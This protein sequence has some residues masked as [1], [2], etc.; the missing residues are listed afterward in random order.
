MDEA[1]QPTQEAPLDLGYDSEKLG[2]LPSVLL[3]PDKGNGD[4]RRTARLDNTLMARLVPL[5][6]DLPGVNFLFANLTKGCTVGRSSIC[7]VHISG[8]M[9]S[10][11]HCRVF[12][13]DRPETWD[14]VRPV[15][16]FIQDLSTNGTFVNGT[17]LGKN[18]RTLLMHGDTVAFPKPAGTRQSQDADYIFQSV[19]AHRQTPT[20]T[21]MEINCPELQNRYDVKHT[22]GTGNFS[23]VKLAI[24]KTSGDSYACK[25]IRKKKFSMQPKVMSSFAREV[26]ILS[27]ISHSNIIRYHEVFENEQY[28]CIMT[29]FVSGA[30]LL[31]MITEQ[32]KVTEHMGRGI[33]YQL[34]SAIEYLHQRG[35]T[36]R[37][38]KPENILIQEQTGL[39]KL[40]DFGLARSL[41]D[42]TF[43]ATMCGTPS[44]I[45]PEIIRNHDGVPRYTQLVDLWSLGVVLYHMLTGHLP[46]N[47]ETQH[48][49]YHNILCGQVGK[50]DPS[51]SQL[52][53]P[54]QQLITSL[55][56]LDP[57]QR[58]PLR[59]VKHHLWF[60]LPRSAQPWGQLVAQPGST[61][62]NSHRLVNDVTFLGRSVK[63]DIQITY[64]TVSKIHCVLIMQGKRLLLQDTSSNGVY[65]NGTVLPKHGTVPAKD[66]DVISFADSQLPNESP[67][68]Y[69]LRLLQ[70]PAGFDSGLESTDVTPQ[71]TP[72]LLAFTEQRTGH[73]P[74][75]ASRPPL[76]LYP[77]KRPAEGREDDDRLTKRLSI[78]T[79]G[80]HT[81][82]LRRVPSRPYQQQR[83]THLPMAPPWLQLISLTPDHE[84]IMVS[85]P[86]TKL[87]REQDCHPQS[88]YVH[89]SIS[90]YHCVLARWP[91]DQSPSTH[92]PSF[93]AQ[94]GGGHPIAWIVSL[95]SNGTFVNGQL[96]QPKVWTPLYLT[97]WLVLA[98]EQ[99]WY[100]N[101]Q[102]P[103]RP[104][105]QSSPH[106]PTVTLDNYRDSC[107]RL[108]SSAL[109]KDPSLLPRM[110]PRPKSESNGLS[111]RSLSLSSNVS[112]MSG[113]TATTSF[114]CCS[115]RVSHVP[116]PPS[117]TYTTTFTP[118]PSSPLTK[119]KLAQVEIG[120]RF[121]L[122]TTSI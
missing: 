79:P 38:L 78:D 118:M 103:P 4:A 74:S 86:V 62:R 61:V 64:Q 56:H 96:L 117:P 25:I 105:C 28:L 34:C 101:V 116:P 40:T 54:V 32:A 66:G 19:L 55:L 58:L 2:L 42:A 73:S 48:Q 100:K 51:F 69:T 59:N 111:R 93:F 49:L 3:S 112:A 89:L 36:H 106:T 17:L 8:K 119:E 65:L 94:P 18:N 109:D 72:K 53:Y 84:D 76:R 60:K 21:G 35:I 99:D 57:H 68:K 81:L 6:P 87:G 27:T 26:Q 91:P 114:S 7:D 121:R 108:D 31:S 52:S 5:N 120:Y 10:Q 115:T 29:E 24:E 46:F 71:S 12:T 47:G 22:V 15:A 1:T 44:Y 63:C 30:D 23:V 9:I 104:H 41:N 107:C 102:Y 50:N 16:V 77:T 37:D 85:E 83:D 43:V 97:D 67:P 82:S 11:T 14:Q 45:A 122:P 88:R 70:S 13:N 75:F 39:V 20:N 33:F 90:S 80:E 92:T 98:Y 95:S 110:V 113:S